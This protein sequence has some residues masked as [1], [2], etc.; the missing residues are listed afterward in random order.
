[1]SVVLSFKVKSSLPDAERAA[2]LRRLES[3]RGVRKA[4]WNSARGIGTRGM[5]LLD[6]AA[7]P[8]VV[9]R[10]LADDPALERPPSVAPRRE[11]IR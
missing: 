6:D 2:A 3:H 4:D 11:L 9:A 7:D 5:L 8:E 10:E 1:M